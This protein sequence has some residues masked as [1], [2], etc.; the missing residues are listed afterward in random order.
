MSPRTFTKSRRPLLLVVAAIAAGALI[1]PAGASAGALVA[2]A[3]DCD[4][5]ALSQPF[6]PWLDPAQYQFAPDGGFES[7]AAGWDLNGA[8]ATT[9]GNE[10]YYV[11]DSGDSRSLALPAGSSATSPTVCVGLEHPTLRFVAK[12]TSGLLATMGVEVLFEDSVGGVHTLPIGVV[13]G[14][15]SWQPTAPMVVVANLLPLLPGDYTP[16]Q[17][18]FTALAGSFKIDDTYVDPWGKG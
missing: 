1:A 7:D 5:Q 12:K 9:S 16:V 10:P 8:A 18:R 4:Q 6:A 13:G 2:S 17:F 15:S 11:H 14:T 3:P